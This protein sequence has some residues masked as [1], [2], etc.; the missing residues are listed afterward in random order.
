MQAFL[1][2]LLL[3]CGLLASFSKLTAQEVYVVTNTE[4]LLVDAENCNVT[5]IG[6]LVDQS[7]Q[8]II[9]VDMAVCPDGTLYMTNSTAIYTANPTTGVLTLVSNLTPFVNIN[10]LACSDANV[11]YGAGISIYE[12]D[13][14]TGTWTTIGPSP[15]P[16]AG[17]L[18]FLDGVLYLA[19][20]TGI[21]EINL[22][23]T[24][25][26]DLVVT[27]SNFFWGL[28]A[29]LG[30]CNSI[31]GGSNSGDLFVLNVETGEETLLCA[32]VGSSVFGMGSLGDF[33][34]PPVDCGEYF[35]DLDDD[36]S[37]GALQA[38]YNGV[39]INCVN[40]TANI[41][42][43]DVYIESTE[44]I[45]TIEITLTNPID[46]ADEILTLASATNVL[47][48]GSGTAN[49]TL[50]TTGT[51]TLAQFEA[52]INQIIYENL[53]VPP[54]AG[55]REVTVV[56]TTVGGNISNIAT[57]F[58]PVQASTFLTVDLGD[59]ITL[60]AGENT[61][62]DAGNPGSTY[63]WS[64]TEQSQTITV[65]AAGT[66]SVTVSNGIDCPGSDEVEVIISPTYQV[67]LSGEDLICNGNSAVLVLDTD[68]PNPLNIIITGTDG[69][70]EFLTGA[71]DGTPLV[72][73]PIVTTT[74]T[75]ISVIDPTGASCTEILAS[76]TVTVED[77]LD[78]GFDGAVNACDNSA[79]FSL[80]DILGGTPD[81]GGVWV[82]ATVSGN[83]LFDPN[84][85]APGI[86]TYNLLSPTGVCPPASS[87][88]EVNLESPPDAGIDANLSYCADSPSF[89]LF[90]L[91]G[92]TPDPGGTW[93]PP[94]FQGNGI[95]DP[96]FDSPGGYIYTVNSA[97]GLCPSASATVVVSLESLPN[98]GQDANIGL[99]TDQ[100][101]ID[102]FSL[103][104]GSPDLGGTWSPTTAAGNGIFNPVVDP[105]GNYVY[106]VNSASGLCPSASATV[107]V[108][109]D[110]LPDAGQD[111]GINLCENDTPI[112]L[113]TLLSGTPDAGG[114]WS[115][116]TAA[117]NGLFDPA[118]DPAGVYTYTVFSASGWCPPANA[119]VIVNVEPI[120]DTTF[121][122][123]LSCDPNQ[124]GMDTM[125]F[126]SV[127]QCD[128]VVVTTT[129][130]APSSEETIIAETCDPSLVGLDTLFLQNEFNCDSLVITN[131]VLDPLD[132]TW[133]SAT[134]CDPT[135]VG[136]DTVVLAGQL[137]DSVV[138]TTTTL[139][140]SSEETIDELTCDPGA[141]GLD[142]LFLQNQFDCDSLVIVNT[143]LSPTDTTWVSA[144][145]CDPSL[146][147]IDTEVLAGQFCDSVVITTTTLLPSSEETIDEL[148]CDPGA[149]GLDTLFLQNEF[150]CDSLVIIN[151]ILSPTDTTWVS[152]TTCDP[153]L[154]GI[155][156]EVLVGQLCDSVVITTTTLLP[157]SEE[158][159]D[160]LTCDPGAVGLDTLFLQNEF[161][162]DSLVIINTILSPTDTTWVS[163]TTCDPSLAGV[164]TEVLAGQLCDSV[165][166]TTTMLLPSSEEMI[167]EL[168]CDPTAVGID[169]LF[170]QN[171][172]DCDSLVIINTV[173]S[174][175]DTT[176]VS[177]TTCDPSL[178][179]IDTEVLAGQ[180]CDSV[181]I[182]TTMLLP[183]SEE[184][185]DELTC[186]PGAVGLDT[187]FLQNQFDCDSLVIINTVLSP[188]DTT[189]VS[190][191]TCD[192]SLAGIDTEVLAGQL[193]DSVVITTTTLL[194][195]SEE[196]IDELTCDPGAVGLDTLFLQNQFNCDSLIIIN[197]VL[198]PID[199]TWV[200]A[201]TC[202][203]TLAGIETEVLA[204]QLCD[205]VV[206]TTTLLLPSSEETIDE[207]TCDPGAVGLD[208][209][210]LQN[211][212]NC[213]SLIIINTVL[214]PADTTWVSATTC[215]PTLAGI[216]TEV[217]AG[218]FC[219]SVV[220]TTT[221]LLP[222]SEETID[223]L[224]C[225]PG[226]V[227]LDTLFLQNEFNCDS[228]IIINTVLS[229]ADTTYI[230]D[231]TCDPDQITNDTIVYNGQL[232]DSVVITT[233]DLLPSTFLEL[234][235]VTCDPTEVSLDTFTFQNQFGCD[236]IRIINTV[237]LPSDTSFAVATTC[238]PLQVG[239]DTTVFAGQI[240]DS[241]VIT[242]TTLLP[243]DTTFVL[244]STC[245]PSL[246]GQDTF[247]FLNELECDSLIIINTVLLDADTTFV[248]AVSCSPADTGITVNTLSN[249]DGCDSVVVT[250]TSLGNIGAVISTNVLSDF[251]GF[252]LSCAE[253]SDGQA[254]VT[255]E[256][257]GTPPFSYTWSNGAMTPTIS[258]L[259]AGLQS[260]TVTD[261]EGCISTG[262]VA[263][264]AP[265]P[266]ALELAVNEVSCFGEDD[267]LVLID[268]V[269]GGTGPYLYTI[270]A[271]PFQQTPQ[272]TNL[273]AGLYQLG[274]QDANG[275]TTFDT[276]LVGSPN[277]LI[278][279]LGDDIFIEL[280]E[281]VPLRAQV[282]TLDSLLQLIEWTTRDSLACDTC[283]EQ[284]V[285][286]LLTTSY[287]IM[288]M[289]NN[290]CMDSDELMIYVEKPRPIYIPS[291][292]SPN[293]DGNND[294]FM[295]F[296]NDA[297]V[298]RVTTFRIFDR[299]GELVFQADNFPPNDP[300]FG[301]N[302]QL[303]GEPLKP[304]VF[305]YVAEVEF[306]DG[307]VKLYKGDVTLMK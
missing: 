228:L 102:L 292:F 172:F 276:L 242:T 79:P 217:F 223:E 293:E 7:G 129:T 178:A 92:G 78:A 255:V 51:T 11:I 1:R 184:T 186:D 236:S 273:S 128:S 199:T 289:D 130:L 98:A 125:V 107:S 229:P 240:C 235:E 294:R 138:I 168:T 285:T 160:E 146:A 84:F 93:L 42:D 28:S 264:T 161:D 182:T 8:P 226:A 214:S 190:A 210:F 123:V 196:T 159:I 3:L 127:G 95:F 171:E 75:I 288:V 278:V 70:N 40:T 266:L 270:D 110:P 272:F 237:L 231:S 108:S 305:V 300:N 56:F 248:S 53:T 18:T 249:V 30:D 194:P 68:N 66:Y 261:S 147:G 122:Q 247:A 87:S 233:Y 297:S 180:L 275:C 133:V 154:A 109:V 259:S 41:S 267:G 83:G 140:P 44:A 76:Q 39:S 216:D 63:L 173:L 19:A 46:I 283:L 176:W 134:T 252:A 55:T 187:L 121:V 165:I 163:A 307:Y 188:A 227:G 16:P 59:D 34:P 277:E 181:V 90:S 282:S 100:P 43:I 120:L 208:T 301:W 286:P 48:A 209:L 97:T 298:A 111:A 185:I 15:S 150:D 139:L 260:V 104:T 250:T 256:N 52:A 175:A 145:T 10:S 169:T 106:T 268:S 254:E 132:T 136:M 6:P 257:G 271:A 304:A 21:W 295:I 22:D 24:F 195:S 57:G 197:T 183:S 245:D 251:G 32:N 220:I 263:L 116:T 35:I 126:N 238:D 232:C 96:A 99:C 200:S 281:S 191:T 60:C 287:S 33:D 37:S 290:G 62:L 206:I 91:L 124:V 258:G 58:I 211:E 296:A 202:D 189:W 61:I 88:V 198:S 4:L 224:T 243:S 213:D 36:N 157:S 144:T 203:P 162:C 152:E 25:N 38:D 215:D 115:P 101:S 64:T 105:A 23:D 114:T 155:D 244:E 170:L 156:T 279:T 269:I 71:V 17:D 14:I 45:S 117:G 135:L 225:D 234:L 230:T 265:P 86:Y 49:I 89:D 137:C 201:T 67:S 148:T 74:Y 112:D 131:T 26:S 280:G 177:N 29:Y 164:D 274:V 118:V 291:A 77:A 81:P 174:P 306:I 218:Q 141:V 241:V 80:F 299:W 113:F 246:V 253:A 205:S 219:D 212:F 204:G 85:D 239:V 27:S 302:G 158:T 47:I 142:T 50:T 167:D 12:I 119:L 2:S 31:I 73:N 179:G 284:S 207:L 303:R 149:V 82:P 166:I 221:T 222:S 13:P 262:T 9:A 69:T 192:P 65:N 143:V 103:L 151:T 193:C 5:T 20:V 94:T 54:S 153:A 72:F